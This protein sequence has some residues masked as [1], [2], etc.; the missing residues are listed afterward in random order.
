MP[1]TEDER[2]SRTPRSQGNGNTPSRQTLYNPYVSL[3]RARQA[4]DCTSPTALKAISEIEQQGILREVTGSRRNRLY[5]ARDI[6][7]LLQAPFSPNKCHA[8]VAS[9][10]GG[11]AP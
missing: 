1:A 8:E 10:E 6:L 3:R 2:I 9:R 7:D 5:V 11:S 4:L